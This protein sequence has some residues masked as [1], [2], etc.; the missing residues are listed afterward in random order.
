MK[1][2]HL[3]D[4][5]N[6]RNHQLHFHIIKLMLFRL[7]G[8]EEPLHEIIKTFST[9]SPDATLLAGTYSFQGYYTL[10]AINSFLDASIDIQC[11]KF[12]ESILRV[13]PGDCSLGFNSLTDIILFPTP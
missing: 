13:P 10:P 12:P 6:H 2:S 5:A 9:P 4:Y 11:E 3:K 7:K 1:R 8:V